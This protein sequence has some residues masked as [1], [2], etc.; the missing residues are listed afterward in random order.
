MTL[1]ISSTNLSSYAVCYAGDYVLTNT[2]ICTNWLTV[3]QVVYVEY[4]HLFL[5]YTNALR[6]HYK[7]QPVEAVQ[8]I[9]TVYGENYTK[10]ID[11]STYKMQRIL[12]INCNI[13]STQIYQAYIVT[14]CTQITLRCIKISTSN[15][16]YSH[17]VLRIYFRVH[18]LM[19]ATWGPKHVVVVNSIPPMLSN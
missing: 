17:I 6:P 13:Q 12:V 3:V 16:L 7:C 11:I 5:P 9:I 2:F 14:I 4:K 18:N 19:M 10:S 8:I 1:K 15:Y